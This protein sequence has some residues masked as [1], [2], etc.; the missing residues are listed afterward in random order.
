MHPKLFS[1]YTFRNAHSRI[2][3]SKRCTRNKTFEGPK[4]SPKKN[5]SY[6][7]FVR[8]TVSS[9]DSSQ[10]LEYKRKK[11]RTTKLKSVVDQNFNNFKTS[12]SKE[13]SY[14][15]P[16]ILIRKTIANYSYPFCLYRV[17]RLGTK[18]KAKYLTFRYIFENS[19]VT[20]QRR[21]KKR[22]AKRSNKVS[23]KR[24]GIQVFLMIFVNFISLINFWPHFSVIYYLHI[25]TLEIK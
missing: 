24:S 19:S 4:N 12:F 10:T 22:N 11:T 6:T 7:F 15:R 8:Q 1:G 18:S 2:Y 21:S 23:H 9:Q 5:Q 20:R 17:W 16:K 13:R 3:A 25:S 14:I